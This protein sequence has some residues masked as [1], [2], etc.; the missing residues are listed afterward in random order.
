MITAERLEE[1]IKQGGTA[2]GYNDKS[3]FDLPLKNTKDRIVAIPANSLIVDWYAGKGKGWFTAYYDP[4][5]LYETKEQ[6]EWVCKMHA[7]RTDRFEPPM[8]ED[9]KRFYG[10]SFY[11]NVIDELYHREEYRFFVD[12]LAAITVVD[13]SKK[14]PFRDVYSAYATKEN[15]I[16]AC[17]IVRDLFN[18]GGAK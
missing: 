4:N 8:W 1:L 16:K 12:K 18:K 14:Q 9:I 17:E 10:F 15:Y 11:G 7:E 6:A 13:I 3:V 5:K 2:W